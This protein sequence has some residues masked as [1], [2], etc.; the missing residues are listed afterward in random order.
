MPAPQLW[1]KTKRMFPRE[2][3]LAVRKDFEEWLENTQPSGIPM[4]AYVLG[5]GTSQFLRAVATHYNAEEK[6]VMYT[7]HRHLWRMMRRL[8]EIDRRSD[9]DEAEEY[10]HLDRQLSYLDKYDPLCIDNFGPVS[11]EAMLR[12]WWDV[13]VP[14]KDAEKR[15]TL[16]GVPDESMLPDYV[17]NHI[18][19]HPAFWAV[20]DLDARR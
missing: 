14:R 19:K 20:V 6:P 9:D 15:P 7:M 17:T 12:T 13:I 10:M 18:K 3:P 5:H 8:D 1:V 11:A 2:L 4:N 16:L